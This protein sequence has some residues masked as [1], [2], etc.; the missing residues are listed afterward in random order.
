MYDAGLTLL[1]SVPVDHCY[2]AYGLVMQH[3]SGWKLV[4]SGDTRPCKA[5]QAAGKDCTLLIHE[6]TFAPELQG[7]AWMKKHSTS[8]EAMQVAQGMGA[9]RTILTHLS[10]RYSKVPFTLA[11][12]GP[13]AGSSMI[14]FDGMRV[15]FALLPVLPKLLT[16]VTS[17]FAVEEEENLAID[18]MLET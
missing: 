5:L 14:A 8:V 4:W 6:A 16:G 15:P 10:Q 17:I 18:G 7:H 9:Y 12:E 11:A 13:A 3:A 2:D 1:Q